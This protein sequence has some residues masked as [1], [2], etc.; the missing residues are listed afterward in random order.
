MKRRQ[1]DP[2][3]TVVTTLRIDRK[4]LERFREIAALDH[5]S[6]AAE[7]RRLI[8]LRVDQHDQAA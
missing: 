1:G 8:E 5:R 3:V 7:I 6:A 4:Q 2:S